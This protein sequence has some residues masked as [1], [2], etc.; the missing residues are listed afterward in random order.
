[1]TRFEVGLALKA[2]DKMLISGDAL[3]RENSGNLWEI[4][5]QLYMSE[6]LERFKSV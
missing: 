4:S 6:L 5:E 3:E 1:M 2:N